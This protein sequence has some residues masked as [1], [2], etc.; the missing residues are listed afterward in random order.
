M[1]PRIGGQVDLVTPH[2]FDPILRSRKKRSNMDF[3]K[4]LLA[5]AASHLGGLALCALYA[6]APPHQ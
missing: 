1:S 3:L 4:M 2:N 6:G 5:I